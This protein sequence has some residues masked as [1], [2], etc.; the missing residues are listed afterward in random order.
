M[1][2]QAIADVDLALR[3]FEEPG[4]QP[5]RRGLAVSLRGPNRQTSLPVV[6]PQRDIIRPPLA[7][8]TAW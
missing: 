6:D 1:T 7:I 2:L 5:Q 8:T 3:G 4:D